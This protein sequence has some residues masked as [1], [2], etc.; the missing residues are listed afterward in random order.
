MILDSAKVES[1][2]FLN[3]TSYGISSFPVLVPSTL[4][5]NTLLSPVNI[6]PSVSVIGKASVILIPVPPLEFSVYRNFKVPVV[7]V[8]SVVPN[9]V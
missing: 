7:T 8:L 9:L 4:K 6:F 5:S 2:F 1:L 3:V